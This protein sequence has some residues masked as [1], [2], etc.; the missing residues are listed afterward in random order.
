MLLL[1]VASVA[2]EDADEDD[3]A[4]NYERDYEHGFEDDSGNKHERALEIIEVI[5]KLENVTLY[6]VC[7]TAATFA[8]AHAATLLIVAFVVREMPPPTQHRFVR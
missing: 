1:S 2:G 4:R 3:Y 8:A 6:N 5:A 7:S